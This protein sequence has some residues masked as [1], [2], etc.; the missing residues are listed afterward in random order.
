MSTNAVL[1]MDFHCHLTTSEVVGYLAGHWD[2]NAH[3]KFPSTLFVCLFVCNI[4][5]MPDV[6]ISF[7]L[8]DV[9]VH[10]KFPSTLFVCL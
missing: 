4:A 10:S 7:I 1:V 5:I 8:G 2:V 6:M 3:S 9:N